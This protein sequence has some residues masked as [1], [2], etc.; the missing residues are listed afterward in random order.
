VI[1]L[2]TGGLISVLGAVL[3]LLPSAGPRKRVAGAA[4]ASEAGAGSSVELPEP[5]GATA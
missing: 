3:A 5:V 4:V 2:W 1:W